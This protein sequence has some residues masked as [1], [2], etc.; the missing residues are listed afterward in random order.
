L[1][2]AGLPVSGPRVRGFESLQFREF[3]LLWLGQLTTALGQWMDQVARGWLL[4]DLTGSPFDLGLVGALRVVP[5]LILSPVAGTFADRYG[6]K[7]Q[8]ILALGINVVANAVLGILILTG[9]VHPWH[10]YATALAVSV[11]VC[12]MD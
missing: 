10:V 4:Y 6:R 8:L 9:D 2:K 1:T 12:R 7:T 3:R 5:L 11:S